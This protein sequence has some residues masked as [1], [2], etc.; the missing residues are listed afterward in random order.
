MKNPGTHWF[1]YFSNNPM[2]E[3]KGRLRTGVLV[4]VYCIKLIY[5][6]IYNSIRSS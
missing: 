4:T 5:L 1:R 6:L 2:T 3:E